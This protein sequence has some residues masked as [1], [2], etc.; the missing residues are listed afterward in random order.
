MSN[1]T[2]AREAL[3]HARMALKKYKSNNKFRTDQTKEGKDRY[4]R[5]LEADKRRIQIM[6]HAGGLASDKSDAG[7][8]GY[9][10]A[11]A[12]AAEAYKAGNCS[13][14]AAVAWKFLIGKG[15]LAHVVGLQGD[16]GDHAFAVVGLK[17]SPPKDFA[18]W[19]ADV[20]ICD[21]WANVCCLAAGYPAAWNEKMRHWSERQHKKIINGKEEHVDPMDHGWLNSITSCQ[22]V[23]RVGVPYEQA[24]APAAAPPRKP[25]PTPPG[26]R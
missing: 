21:P 23:I 3:V 6:K 13:E 2:P 20:W 17:Q 9:Y 14:Y 8:R 25:L 11:L 10:E 22:K 18:N 16:K 5:R 19:G 4:E 1:E 7:S 26:K 24:P 15:A 12:E